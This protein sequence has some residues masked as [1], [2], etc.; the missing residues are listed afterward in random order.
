MDELTR[1]QAAVWPLAT[2]AAVREQ[3]RPP[4]VVQ[5][6]ARR[7]PGRL[8][9]LGVPHVHDPAHPIFGLIREAFRRTRPTRVL[10]EGGEPTPLP[11][12]G[13][14]IGAYGEIG[15]AAWLA[16]FGRVRL[17]SLEPW[18]IDEAHALRAHADPEAIKVFTVMRD[19]V[20]WH[21]GHRVV[22][23]ETHAQ[24]LLDNLARGGVPGRPRTV[25]ELEAAAARWLPELADWRQA[26]AAWFDPSQEG[27][28]TQALARASSEVRDRHMVRLLGC[29]VD[30]GARVVAVMGYSHAV[31]QAPGLAL[32]LDDLHT[33]GLPPL[34]SPPAAPSTSSG[35]SPRSPRPG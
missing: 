29:A 9:V 13:D 20:T 6:R 27:T 30:R 8:T 25:A 32:L 31:T 21:R 1:A 2:Y 11:T 7:G 34:T 18:R 19:L 15:L 26:P 24:V 17:G 12:L 28:W 35:R 3:V 33:R 10:V 22:S 23:I 4:V 5:G 16:R 14:M